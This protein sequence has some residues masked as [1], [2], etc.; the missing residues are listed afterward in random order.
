[1][2]AWQSMS[3]IASYVIQISYNT[4]QNYRIKL[5]FILFLGHNRA[6]LQFYLYEF[7]VKLLT[8]YNL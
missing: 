8:L 7:N 6:N 5:F 1:M 2:I 3:N 4:S